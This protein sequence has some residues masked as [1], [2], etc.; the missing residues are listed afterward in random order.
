METVLSLQIK[1]A[2]VSLLVVLRL[3]F[4]MLTNV[5]SLRGHSASSPTCHPFYSISIVN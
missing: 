5:I 1:F 3:P 4:G 2:C